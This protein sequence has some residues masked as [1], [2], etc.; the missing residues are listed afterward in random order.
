MPA[1]LNQR[2][3]RRAR[4][5]RSGW[6]FRARCMF[7]ALGVTPRQ[8]EGRALAVLGADCA[9]Y[10]SGGGSLISG[11]GRTP[12]RRLAQRR[13][14]LFF[15]PMRG[16][17]GEPDLGGVGSDA[18]LAADLFQEAREDF[19]K[20]P[21]LRLPPGRVMAR[22]RPR[23]CDNPSCAAFASTSALRR[24]CGIPRKSIG[25]D[26]RSANARPRESPELGCSR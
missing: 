22:A 17:V 11:S 19:I 1:G 16:F 24:R 13:V 12:F 20:S 8:D 9:E 3:A 6:R 25:R 10:I 2:A 26:R 21:Q 4:P 18:L 5:A 15:W 23:A 7:M 14:I